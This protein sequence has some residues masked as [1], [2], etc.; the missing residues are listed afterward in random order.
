MS[1]SWPIAWR[2]A[3]GA[4]LSLVAIGLTITTHLFATAL[5]LLVVAAVLYVDSWQWSAR[6]AEQHSPVNWMRWRSRPG[7]PWS[8]GE[9][10]SALSRTR[11]ECAFRPATMAAA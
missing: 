10:R 6:R 2:T 11:P 9:R 1:S 4:I 8:D 3:L 5:L 7:A